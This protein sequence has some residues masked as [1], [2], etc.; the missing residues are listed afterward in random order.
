MAKSVEFE[1][2]ILD[3]TGGVL[4]R[5][6]VETS[7]VDAAIRNITRSAEEASDK[8]RKMADV[9]MAFTTLNQA[10]TQVGDITASLAAPFNSFEDAMAK[11]NTMAGKNGEGLENLTDRV[12]DLSEV[13]PLA[14][15]AIA[16]GLYQTIS[17]GV[18]EAQWLE[19]LNSSAR[20]AVG[21][22]ADLGGV[23]KVTSGIIKA[24][25]ADWAEAGAIQDKI[26]KT[27]K[28]GVTSFEELSQ[29]LPRV[30]GNAATLG[31]TVD[32]LMAVFATTT[33]V[34]GNTAEVSTQL[35]AVLNSL[36][37][38]SSEATKAAQAMGISFD[39]ASVKSAGGLENFLLG[40]DKSIRE[41][42]EKTGTLSETIYGQL[43]GSTEALR[44][45][46][47]LTG[48]QK[49]TFSANISAMADSAGT[50]DE[51]FAQ[52]SE[53]GNAQATMFRNAIDGMT[54]WI[55]SVASSA[56]PTVEL[57][58]NLGGAITTGGQ[59][60]ATFRT[61][62]SVM[63]LANIKAVAAAAAAKGAAIASS[64]WE[65]AQAALNFVL[66]ANPIGIV[67]M[68]IAALVAAIVYAYNNCEEFREICDKV[69][70]VIKDVASA[71]WDWLVKA[72]DDCSAAIKKAWEWVKAFF[73]ISDEG[74][75][76][77]Q[78]EALDANTRATET[79]TTAKAAA[80]QQAMALK[81][82]NDWQKMSYKQLGEAIEEQKVKVA[83]LSD[84]TS[85]EAQQEVKLLRQMEARYKTLGKS[86]GLTTA[87]SSSRNEFDGKKLIAGASTYKELGNNIQYYR[88]KLETTKPSE[89]DEINRLSRLI[90]E[91]K[92]AQESIEGLQA[93]AARPA[94]MTSLSDYD[95]ELEYLG[96]TRSK[97][98][99]AEDLA[100]IDDKI[101]EVTR[102]RE[103]MEASAFRVVPVENIDT[104]EELSRQINHYQQQLQKATGTTRAEIQ[105]QI[106]RLDKLKKEWDTAMDAVGITS[107]ASKLNSLEDVEK[108][109]SH[110]NDRRKKASAE[111]YD[112]IAATI[113]ALQR[114][115]DTLEAMA[116]LS[117]I[118]ARSGELAALGSQELKL[119]LRL[120][121]ADEVKRTVASLKAMLANPALGDADRKGL[122]ALITQWSNYAKTLGSQM[123]VSDGVTKS[124][125]GISDMLGSVAEMTD[126]SS[127]KMLQWGAKT[128]EAC[129]KAFVAIMAVTA[130]KAAES[131]AD[132]PVVG[133]ILAGA[134]IASVIAAFASIPKFAEGGIA[135]GPTLGIF[136]EYA[137]ASNNPEV[138]AP[139]D[140]LR[141]LIT[142]GGDS[143]GEYRTVR[144]EIPGRKLVAILEKEKK[145]SQHR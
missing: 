111:E 68:A 24:Y 10:L 135:Y 20:S 58:A 63:T 8:I 115:A 30:T 131:V 40:L 26:Q 47:S 65:G 107:D 18:P 109:L 89:I 21:G 123:S 54:G 37:K 91:A 121:G 126:E 33:N 110:F 39:A 3:K 19:Y 113:R 95:K 142:P 85:K 32:E 132:I 119:R 88:N 81:S 22:C 17:A 43:F 103:A 90:A 53:T 71:V 145:F 64:I 73:G 4:K 96:T 102:A 130:G 116:N 92:K 66:S 45:L 104:Y 9:G 52:M 108:A 38:P 23:V 93:A 31:V 106:N 14:R 79:N 144:V 82:A 94:E 60:I 16:D 118:K 129:S 67:V 74:P 1:V 138:V 6:A 86:L 117:D 13:V 80:A 99:S 133:W 78:T 56:A 134:A 137:G 105:E 41:Y 120:I 101:A 77:A 27:A 75:T 48:E 35:A 29:A 15:E 136:G 100:V 28:L 122:E 97:A 12:Q 62:S 44:L 125:G 36:V 141:S 76:E 70:G 83:G 50:M 55:G 2:K 127:A 25:G 5:I 7:D 11:V 140:K 143:G 69:W 112:E 72:F 87:A 139:L 57:V 98:G 59:L 42:S 49:D 114:K 51:A 34:T 124:M 61:L 84:A 128:I 46:G